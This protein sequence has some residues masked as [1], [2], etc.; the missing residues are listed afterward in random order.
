MELILIVLASVTI[1]IYLI[2]LISHL[3]ISGINKLI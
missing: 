2:K 3:V 1:P